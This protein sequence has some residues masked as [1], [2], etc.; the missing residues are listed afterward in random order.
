MPFPAQSMPDQD[1]TG[2]SALL[3]GVMRA[4]T[5]EAE[6]V[7]MPLVDQLAQ[8]STR[9]EHLDRRIEAL[10]S[11]KEADEDDG[12][13]VDAGGVCRILR[14]KPQRSDVLTDWMKRGLIPDFEARG[15][16]RTRLWRASAV[17]EHARKIKDWPFTTGEDGRCRPQ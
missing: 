5:A 2:L 7:L 15:P 17:K 8:L 16:N 4:F 1:D 12:G 11:T 9:V 14:R 13:F 10:E 6:R 3:G